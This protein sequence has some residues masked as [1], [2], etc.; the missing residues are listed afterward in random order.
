MQSITSIDEVDAKKKK[1]HLKKSNTHH[2]KNTQQ[3]KT[4]SELPQQ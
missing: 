4:K 2:N 3:T 1:N